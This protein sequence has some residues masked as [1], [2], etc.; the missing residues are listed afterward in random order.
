MKNLQNLY[1]KNYKTSRGDKKDGRRWAPLLKF[2]YQQ[3]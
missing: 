2:P 3:Q 1:T